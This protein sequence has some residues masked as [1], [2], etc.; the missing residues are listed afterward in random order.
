MDDKTLEVKLR[1]GVMFHNGVEM[2]ADDVVFTFERIIAENMI[3]YP[4]APH[5]AAQGP[6]RPAG[7]GREG[8]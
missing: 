6:G 7:D 5:L 8:G 2:T 4:E 1:Q 3:E